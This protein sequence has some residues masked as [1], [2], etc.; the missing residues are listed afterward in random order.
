MINKVC[1]LGKT[2]INNDS[3]WERRIQDG[4]FFC[5]WGRK[6]HHGLFFCQLFPARIAIVGIDLG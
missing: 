3:G 5:G 2:E 1:G 4:L 6:F